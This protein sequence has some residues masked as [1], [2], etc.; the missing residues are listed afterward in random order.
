MRWP[1]PARRHRARPRRQTS[2]TRICRT[3]PRR[4]RTVQANGSTGRLAS[5]TRQIR[6][7]GASHPPAPPDRPAPLHHQCQF[8]RAGAQHGFG[9]ARTTDRASVGR[10]THARASNPYSRANFHALGLSRTARR[11]MAEKLLML[12]GCW[13]GSARAA[14]PVRRGRLGAR[15]GAD[16]RE[17]ASRG[18]TG[19]VRSR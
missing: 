16:A 14:P 18:R 13:A 12:P 5:A 6:E 1:L 19:S 15:R 10:W 4:S 8:G 7:A 3:P 17:N 11:I 2:P 9:R